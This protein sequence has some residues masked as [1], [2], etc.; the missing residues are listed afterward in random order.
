MRESNIRIS[1]DELQRMIEQDEVKTANIYHSIQESLLVDFLGFMWRDKVY[2]VDLLN[3]ATVEVDSVDRIHQITEEMQN[4]GYKNVAKRIR[5]D[6]R[7]VDGVS[8]FTHYRN[9]NA[10]ILGMGIARS[11]FSTTDFNLTNPKISMNEARIKFFDPRRDS[12]AL[13]FEVSYIIVHENGL[14]SLHP[15]HL[16]A[17]ARLYPRK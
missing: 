2:Q 12:A 16:L 6:R 13:A 4:I 14:Y 11:T 7:G 8:V 10:L 9:L 15:K 3:G 17:A 5:Y 1:F